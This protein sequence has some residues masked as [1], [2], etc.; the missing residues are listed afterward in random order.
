MTNEK[1]KY[2][3]VLLLFYLVTYQV[4]MCYC[5]CILVQHCLARVASNVC[6]CVC[7]DRLCVDKCVCMCVSVLAEIPL[8]RLPLAAQWFIKLAIA[9]CS[10][11]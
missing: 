7:A 5:T 10:I 6:E 1:R 3:V 2:N 11:F 4:R 9:D 8:K